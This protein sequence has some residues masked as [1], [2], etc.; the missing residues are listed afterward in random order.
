MGEKQ[1]VATGLPATG[2]KETK[3]K[4]QQTRNSGKDGQSK[5]GI[6]L[7][8][9]GI[10]PIPS[11]YTGSHSQITTQANS[12]TPSYG[13]KIASV[14]KTHKLLSRKWMVGTQEAYIHRKTL[15]LTFTT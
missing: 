3:E 2:E 11:Y 8:L 15:T 14:T 7:N 13:Q 10:R 9:A 4:G 6:R 5:R 12:A 1:T